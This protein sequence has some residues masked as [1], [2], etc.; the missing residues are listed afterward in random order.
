MPKTTDYTKVAKLPSPPL[1]QKT[2]MT[3]FI[4]SK[5]SN[6]KMNIDNIE[7]LPIIH[8]IKINQVLISW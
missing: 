8:N 7:Y 4:K 5:T 2:R 3:T 6:N 1:I